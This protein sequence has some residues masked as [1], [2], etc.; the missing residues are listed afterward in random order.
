MFLA[1]Y[2]DPQGKEQISLY[3]EH[4]DFYRDTFNPYCEDIEVCYFTIHGKTYRERKESCIELAKRVQRMDTGG[5]SYNEYFI[6][7]EYFSRMARKFGLVQE[8]KENGIL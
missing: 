4:D 2:K 1:K 6:I 3:F 7:G 8:F 5:L